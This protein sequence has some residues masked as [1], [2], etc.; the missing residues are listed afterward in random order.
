MPEAVITLDDAVSQVGQLLRR[1][2]SQ[3]TAFNDPTKSAIRAVWRAVD[4]TRLHLAAI[5]ERRADRDEPREELANLWSDAALAIVDVDP[6]FAERLRSKADYWSD[7][8]EWR[9]DPDLDT[10]IDSVAADARRLLRY[11]SRSIPVSQPEPKSHADIFI[12][13]A[14]EDKEEVAKP[15]ADNL[16]RHGYPVWLDQYVLRLGDGLRRSIDNGLIKC[17]FGV[18][19]LSPSFFR[20]EWPQRELDGLVA[21]ETQDG[22]K[23]ILPVWHKIDRADV[24]LHS[25]TLA[26]RLAVSTSLGMDAVVSEIIDVL[27]SDS[28]QRGAGRSGSV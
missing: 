5:R 27:E 14:S 9:E 3:P 15:L 20:K 28:A 1:L 21:L 19:I 18:V 17:R 11:A 8:H 23:R 7:P 24:V 22:R 6:R 4:Q 2:S 16:D 26:D 12:S 10:S 25:P 13:H